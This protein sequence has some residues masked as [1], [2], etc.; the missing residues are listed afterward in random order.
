MGR[1]YSSQADSTMKMN[2]S[3]PSSVW[4]VGVLCFIKLCLQPLFEILT[5]GGGVCVEGQ[6]ARSFA[7][8]MYDY[9]ACSP[10]HGHAEGGAVGFADVSFE[11]ET[12]AG[13]VFEVRDFQ[14][15]SSILG[16]NSS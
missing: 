13:K 9:G 8:L 15:R 14:K 6:I 11:K 5:F 1:L 4:Y 3:R 12:D 7:T 16:N 10:I 2:M